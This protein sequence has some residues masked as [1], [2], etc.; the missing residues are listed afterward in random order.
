MFGVKAH[1]IG[2]KSLFS[3]KLIRIFFV[4]LPLLCSLAT[5]SPL[6]K[7]HLLLE[8]NREYSSYYLVHHFIVLA[9][10]VYLPVEKALKGALAFVCAIL[11]AK[12]SMQMEW[13][14][15]LIKSKDSHANLEITLLY[16]QKELTS[17][18][19][20]FAESRTGNMIYV[21]SDAKIQTTLPFRE[22]QEFESNASARVYEVTLNPEKKFTFAAVNTDFP[23][24]SDNIY[25][26]KVIL[27]RLASLFRHDLTPVIIAGDIGTGP[28]SWD[29][30][31]FKEEGSFALYPL[32]KAF[33]LGFSLAGHPVVMTTEPF[34]VES[35]GNIES[36]CGATSTR[37][38]IAFR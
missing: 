27:K 3:S 21:S 15:L 13:D 1:L 10:L 14:A 28:F 30:R 29:Y 17:C 4:Y 32:T 2:S 11:I 25:L 31:Q 20:H 16:S 8:L 22:V 12:Y 33:A 19:D 34:V 35:I 18:K 5:S 6:T 7:M 36:G 26:R 37:I 38:D 24:D 9:L 23:W